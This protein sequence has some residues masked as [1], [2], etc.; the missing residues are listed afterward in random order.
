MN[1]IT[2]A[3]LLIICSL[4]L[5]PAQSAKPLSIVDYYNI[6]NKNDPLSF[7]NGEWQTAIQTTSM[8]GMPVPN[9][10]NVVDIQNG[11]I[12]F[13]T[14]GGGHRK[15]QHVLFLMDN[16]TPF[17]GNNYN[18]SDDGFC[19][20]E[21]S[22]SFNQIK[23]GKSTDATSKIIPKMDYKIFLIRNYD[24]K[25]YNDKVL[26]I[27]NKYCKFSFDLPRY[28]LKVKVNLVFPR[29]LIPECW[30][31]LL[32]ESEKSLIKGIGFTDIFRDMEMLWD[33]KTG[34]F[35]LLD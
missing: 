25:K 21:S 10:P 13:F 28:G 19:K 30:D 26:S 15:S 34:T 11:Y 29:R 16:G 17:I 5:M 22:I 14:G 1:K 6:I 7:K 23:D 8:M 12:E 4:F 35:K 18:S 2:L 33:T 9:I 24:K 32:Q 27:I 3:I 31:G 20:S